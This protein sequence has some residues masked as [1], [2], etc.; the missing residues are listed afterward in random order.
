MGPSCDPQAVKPVPG[1]LSSYQVVTLAPGADLEARARAAMLAARPGT[2]IDFPAG[3]Y[4]IE[5]ELNLD[6]SHVA[7][8]GKGMD[9][10]I[11][12]FRNQGAGAQGIVVSADAVVIQDLAVEDTKGDAIK[13]QLANGVT[14]DRVRVE[15]TNGPA[16]TNGAYGFYPVDCENVLIQNSVVKGASDAGIY[17][18]QSEKIVVRYNDVQLNVAGIEIENSRQADVYLNRVTRNTG[19]IL[20]FDLPGLP[21][22]GGRNVRVFLNA[23]FENDT[24]NFAHGG[25]VGLVPAGTGILVLAND[26]VELMSNFV[27]DNGTIGIAVASYVAT[28][29]PIPAPAPGFPVYDA[30]PERVYVH[31]NTLT[32]NGTT[33]DP[34]T[35]FGV[36]LPALFMGA[37]APHVPDIIYDGFLDPAKV[38]PDGQLPPHLRLC[39][40]ENTGASFGTLGGLAA[41]SLDDTPFRCVHPSQPTVALDP[42]L[43]LPAT[44]PLHTP[45]EIDALCNAPGTGVNWAAFEVDCP[46]LASY[47]LF[48]GGD[49]RQD[50]SP[51]GVLYDLTTPLFSD[52][53]T[54]YRFVFLPPASPGDPPQPAL[55]DA[56]TALDFPLGTI[57]AKTFTFRLDQRDPSLGERWIETRLL[58]HRATGWVGLPYVWSEDRAR[59]TLE[60]GGTHRDVSWVHFDGETR[61]TRYRVPNTSQCTACHSGP[62][63]DEPIG[64]TARLLNRD[65][66]YPSGV[67][68]QLEHW[69][70]NGFLAGL[71]ALPVSELPRLPVWNDPNDGTLETRARAYLEINCA[72]CHNP[73]GRARFSGLHLAASVPVGSSLGICKPPVAAGTGGG[74]LV[75][76]IVPGDP[77]SSI[78]VFRMA[79]VDPA[80]QMPELSKSVVHA[81]GVQLIASWIAT[82]PGSC[83]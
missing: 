20:V 13:V 12:S 25:A 7:L 14:I 76:D 42:P 35:D 47:R 43:P 61:V 30:Y 46:E 33:G 71:P 59:A 32:N 50:P 38:Q 10:T 79:S 6:V 58:I 18:G 8:R 36:L 64:P 48:A 31:G 26:E 9:Q 4:E 3:F 56:E 54:K 72:H 77:A 28:F 78:L 68:N 16:R 24:P 45:E 2:V 11:L 41:I 75:Y 74:N 34:D 83:P 15:W 69:A 17:V 70:S 62:D 40:H 67:E 5:G 37:G 51:G 27:H 23:V 65:L 22:Q 21:K 73:Q 44:P 80:V 53:A 60:P 57:I 52:Y 82:L 1:D 49:P 66:A 81:E 19:G 29:L 55:Y 63:G 39:V